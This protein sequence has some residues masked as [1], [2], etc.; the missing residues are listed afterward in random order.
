MA[1]MPL[2]ASVRGDFV[3]LLVLVE[4]TDT[5]DAVA[6]KVAHHVIDRRLPPRE[7]PLRVSFND[8]VIAPGSTVAD[9]GIGPMDYVEVFFDE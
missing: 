9:A 4:D 1:L 5:M 3:V 8:K 6:A 2:Q 7:G